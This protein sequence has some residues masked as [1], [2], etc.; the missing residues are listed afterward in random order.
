[1]RPRASMFPILSRPV[2]RPDLSRP[3][4]TVDL[5]GGSVESLL[6]TY[7]HLIHGA[8]YDDPGAWQSTGF[9]ARKGSR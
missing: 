5:A 3:W 4:T 6:S 8:N 9:A 1:M 7:M 2:P